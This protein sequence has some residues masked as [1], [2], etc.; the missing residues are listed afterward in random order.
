MCLRQFPFVRDS[1]HGYGNT[2]IWNST[3]IKKWGLLDGDGLGHKCNVLQALNSETWIGK[4][5]FSP[6]V[7]FSMGN[8]TN[9]YPEI[10]EG[11]WGRRGEGLLVGTSRRPCCAGCHPKPAGP[12]SPGCLGGELHMALGRRSASVFMYFGET[13]KLLGKHLLYFF[14]LICF[15]SVFWERCLLLQNSWFVWPSTSSKVFWGW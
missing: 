3:D 12:L 7:Y 2:L 5:F 13:K 4:R 1:C 6:P 10:S 11:T 14:W 8:E 9:A 15:V